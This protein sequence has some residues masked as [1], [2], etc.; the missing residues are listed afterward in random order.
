MYYT[1]HS[2][3]TQTTINS[4]RTAMQEW[5]RRT[6]LRFILRTRSSITDYTE[7]RSDDIGCKSNSVGRKGGKQV[8]NLQPPRCINHGTIVHEIG[9]AVGFWH[10]Q[11]RPDRNSYIRVNENNIEPGKSRQ[12]QV[13]TRSEV[14]YYG[15][16]YDYGSIMHYPR[17]AFNRN[18]RPTIEVTNTAEYNRQHRP[19]LGQRLRLSDIDVQQANRLYSCSGSNRIGYLSVQ[20]SHANNLPDEDGW[21]AG[22]SDPYMRVVATDIFGFRETR[23][24]RHIQENQSP[25]WNQR[26]RFSGR[27]PWNRVEVTVYDSDNG[28]DDRLTVTAVHTEVNNIRGSRSASVCGTNNCCGRAYYTIYF[29]A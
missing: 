4:I 29:V 12:F 24:S 3:L 17:N 9:H 5:S 1:F 8:I 14:N 15:T 6:C 2:S 11:S 23:S 7:F 13:R 25:R 27:R 26:L 20:A 21:L 16:G 22:R 19:M 18:G 10:E 28:S